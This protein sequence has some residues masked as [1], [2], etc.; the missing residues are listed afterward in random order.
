VYA[1]AAVDALG[2]PAA[3]GAPALSAVAS[4][5]A[6]VQPTQ[7][8]DA[9]ANASSADK[10][11]AAF[12]AGDYGTAAYHW[13]HAIVDDSQNPI[14]LMMLAQALFATG[15]FDEAAG[16]TQAAMHALPKD[17]WG[18]VI[19]NYKELYGKPQDYA[20]Q[21]RTLENAVREKPEDPGLRFL[22][23]FHY[24]YLGYPQQ[25]IDQIDRVLKVN[26]RDE[27]AKQLRDEMRSK[28]P[29]NTTPPPPPATV[30]Q[31]P[32]L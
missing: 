5:Q 4:T 21:L 31:G 8:A 25:S 15:K 22:T 23:G 11:E 10:G 14:L 1:D 12:K 27:V 20:D 2:Y 29:A 3:S 18:V 24:A 16:A 6:V 32:A 26:P 7:S 9:A 30:P 17:K 28:L 13:R 19:S